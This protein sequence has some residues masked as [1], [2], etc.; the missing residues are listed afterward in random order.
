MGKELLS[1]MFR[2]KDPRTTV[3]H[4]LRACQI[5]FIR[6]ESEDENTS[7]WRVERENLE[8]QLATSDGIFSVRMLS[9]VMDLPQE[10]LLAFYRRLLEL[11]YALMADPKFSVED[12]NVFLEV[13]YTGDRVEQERIEFGIQLLRFAALEHVGELRKEFGVA[14]DDGDSS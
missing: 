2:S 1:R 11:N 4:A 5:D 12:D 7:H 9:R 10:K 6:E 14:E 8:V 3:E 13:T